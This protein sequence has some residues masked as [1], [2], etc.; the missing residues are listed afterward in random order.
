[1]NKNLLNAVCLVCAEH[2]IDNHVIFTTVGI[3][4]IYII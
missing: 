3:F 2:G 1:M 4:I